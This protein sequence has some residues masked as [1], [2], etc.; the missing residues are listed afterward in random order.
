MLSTIQSV[1]ESALPESTAYILNPEHD[2]KHFQAIV[3]CPSFEG[4]PL[5]KQ[6]QVVMNALKA[7]LETKVHALA[8]KTFTPAAW[9]EK[10][11]LYS[12]L[13]SEEVPNE[14]SR[15][16]CKRPNKKRH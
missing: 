4:V 12:Y 7:Q 9:A 5:V 6:H 16:A 10:K 8:L 1:I 15:R 14:Q 3:I 11:H 2:G 13:E